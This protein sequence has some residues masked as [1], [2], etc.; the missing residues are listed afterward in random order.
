MTRLLRLLLACSVFARA[1]TPA[2]AQISL[3]TA[4]DLALK[5]SPKAQMAKADV[6]KAQAALQELRDA[7]IPAVVGSSGLGPPSYGFPLGQP[8]IFSIN[9][10]SLVF[11]Y[12][13]RDYIRSARATLDA[14]NLAL[15]DVRQAVAEET[16]LT[17]VALDRD[18]QRQSALNAEVGF[19]SLLIRIV[20][21]RLDAGQ[22]TAINLTTA[23]LSEAQIRLARLRADDETN[24]DQAHL[25]Q[26]I[27]LPAQG[28][29]IFSIS[30]P[31]IAA[32]EPDSP[33]LP[34]ASS[35]AVESAYASARSKREIAFGDARYIFRPQI[36]FA[37]QYSRFAKFNNLQD[38]YIR[39]Q[40]NNAAIGVQINLPLFDAARR[41][42]A[43]QSAADA[44]HSEREA[45]VTR[46]QFF[47]SRL[48]AQHTMAELVVRAEVA[49]LDQ[50]L[51]QQQLDILLIQLK[52]GTGNSSG[53]Q[54]SPKDEQASRIAER[55]KFLSALDANFQMRQAQINLLRQTGGLDAWL[56]LAAQTSGTP[57]D[58][59][60][61]SKP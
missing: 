1:M 28:L 31:A 53:T 19:S 55:E 38:Y 5:N 8:S 26:L 42:K 54:M 13:Q 14:A 29:S 60:T 27:G 12:S 50:Q 52:S 40:Q 25:A 59:L 49:G 16:A 11:S 47:E 15:T 56:R 24:F 21:E 36:S 3:S 20:Q 2:M 35:P 61:V 48:K 46:N 18:T 57:T 9:A 4:V 23:R 17:F 43:R 22:D 10:Q 51:A 45:D 44:A 58:S 37:A 39:F 33:S 6:D 30:I 7:Y 41:A 32:P 34:Q